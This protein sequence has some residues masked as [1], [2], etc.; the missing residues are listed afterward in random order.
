[1]STLME[2]IRYKTGGENAKG[3]WKGDT[4]ETQ[5]EEV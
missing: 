3:D 1:M 4:A 2:C 5:G